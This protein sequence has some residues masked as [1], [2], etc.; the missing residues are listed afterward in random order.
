M[1]RH[2]S[3]ITENGANVGAIVFI[4][5]NPTVNPQAWVIIVIERVLK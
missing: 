3:L 4:I 1:K 5:K 2:S